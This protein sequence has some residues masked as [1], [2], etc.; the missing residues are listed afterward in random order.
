VG[1]A[2]SS[3]GNGALSTSWIENVVAPAAAGEL[4]AASDIAAAST[5][6]QANLM[7]EE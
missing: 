3:V 1:D 7:Y 4:I 2:C 5:E 6:P